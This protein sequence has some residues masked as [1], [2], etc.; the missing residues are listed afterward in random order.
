MER[1]M[2][3]EALLF[4]GEGYIFGEGGKGY[5]RI[6]LA[7]PESVLQEALERLEKALQ[8]KSLIQAVAKQSFC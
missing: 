8:K 2:T 1:F 3:H 5:E 7:C 4:L 6:N